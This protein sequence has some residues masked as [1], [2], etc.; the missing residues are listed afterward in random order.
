MVI[1]KCDGG[2]LS[3]IIN[4]RKHLFYPSAAQAQ[5]HQI[6]QQQ[7]VKAKAMAEKEVTSEAASE[8]TKEENYNGVLKLPTPKLRFNTSPGLG[9]DI[10]TLDFLPCYGGT[11]SGR[12][13]ERIL[14]IDG[15]GKAVLCD[16]DT[17]II[18]IMPSLDKPKG[19]DPVSLCVTHS[20]A[21]ADL[22]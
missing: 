5:Q 12:G 10:T 11:G 3:R 22:R 14:G 13:E 15:N 19:W 9:G 17:G 7:K 18:E 6:Q 16:A 4:P 21:G 8:S 20:T 1:D 2:S